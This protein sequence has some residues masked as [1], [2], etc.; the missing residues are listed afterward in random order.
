MT[1]GGEPTSVTFLLSLPEEDPKIFIYE[2]CNESIVTKFAVEILPQG[3]M[4]R[5]IEDEDELESI[6]NL[7]KENG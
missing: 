6:K 7:T 4:T 3:L 1:E 2:V 5:K